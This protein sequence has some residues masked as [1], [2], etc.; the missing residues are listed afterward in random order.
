MFAVEV[1]EHRRPAWREAVAD[2]QALGEPEGLEPADVRLERQLPLATARG[3]VGGERLRPVADQLQHRARPWAV[4]AGVH[5]RQPRADRLQFLVA[6]LGRLAQRP[7]WIL[8]QVVE[9]DAV[10]P[11]AA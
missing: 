1:L 9:V 7:T 6:Q 10:E 3:E 11:A 4:L 8:L 2:G 5:S